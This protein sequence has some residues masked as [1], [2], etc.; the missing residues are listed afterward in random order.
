MLGPELVFSQGKGALV[1]VTEFVSVKNVVATYDLLGLCRFSNL[2]VSQVLRN[3]TPLN[4]M[5]KVWSFFDDKLS[6]S[7]LSSM[8][9]LK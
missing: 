5:S 7:V 8:C 6:Y 2:D 9:I 1:A 4:A 3:R